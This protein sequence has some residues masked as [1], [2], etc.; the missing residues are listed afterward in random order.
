M[1]GAPTLTVCLTELML[2]SLLGLTVEAQTPSA[3]RHLSVAAIAAQTIPATVTVLANDETGRPVAL[4]SGFVIRQSVL[5]NTAIV[6]TNWHVIA[7]AVTA[8]VKFEERGEGIPVTLLGGDSTRDVALL[9]LDVIKLPEHL[10]PLV[11]S[12]VEPAIGDHIVVVGNPMGLSHT[13]SDGIV[14]AVRNEELIH[15]IQITAA[16]SH[17]SSGGPVLDDAGRV[18]GI[19]TATVGDGQSLNF[20][21]PVRYALA[22]LSTDL[23][24]HV[25]PGGGRPRRDAPVASSGSSFGGGAPRRTVDARGIWMRPRAAVVRPSVAGDYIARYYHDNAPTDLVSYGQLTLGERSGW[26]AL[27]WLGIATHVDD[28]LVDGSGTIQMNVSGQTWRGYETDSGFVVVHHGDGLDSAQTTLLSA[29]NSFM[30]RAQCEGRLAVAGRTS[31]P[32]PK[33][34]RQKGG[35]RPQIEWTGEAVVYLGLQVQYFDLRLKGSNG[36]TVTTLLTGSR[37]SGAET[38]FHLVSSDGRARLDTES[39]PAMECGAGLNDVRVNWTF[40]RATDLGTDRGELT[41]GPRL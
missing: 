21:T 38:P 30:H 40:T 11:I 14:S 15:L 36:D 35:A 24:P 7:D 19:S 4:G 29:K 6:V 5:T 28:I 1:R 20:A 8:T 16:I 33:A 13:V 3:S 32:A 26:S 10:R 25:F 37:A 12:R 39:F 41:L 31:D 17:G 34:A 18:F 2:L 23:Q 9:G 22:L 27:T